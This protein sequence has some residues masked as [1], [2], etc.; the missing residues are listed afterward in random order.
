MRGFNGKIPNY[1]V[2]GF[3]V[4]KVDA[5]NCSISNQDKSDLKTYTQNLYLHDFSIAEL[6][7]EVRSAIFR[8]K[9][10]KSSVV[11]GLWNLWQS[12]AVNDSFLTFGMNFEPAVRQHIKRDLCLV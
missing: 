4:L 11:R 8:T 2:L 12:Y 3:L 7:D 6:L 1:F 9:S 5:K 10:K